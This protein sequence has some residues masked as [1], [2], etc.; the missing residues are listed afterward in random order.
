MLFVLVAQAQDTLTLR[1]VPTDTS[2]EAFSS[3]VKLKTSF[4]RVDRLNNALNQAIADLRNQGFLEASVDSL[5]RS[6]NEF[7]ACMHVGQQYQ[8]LRLRPGNVEPAL[9][10][11]VGF[12]ERVFEGRPVRIESVRALQERLLRFAENHGYP[13]AIAGLDSVEIQGSNVSAALSFSRNELI[14]FDTVVI[15]GGAQ[16]HPK[17]LY[18]YL[19]LKPGAPYSEAIVAAMNR[20]LRELPF[21]QQTKLPEVTF[22]RDGARVDL[23]LDTR[24]V[25]RVNGIIGVLPNSDANDGKLLITADVDLDL[26]NALGLG[27]QIRLRWKNLQP[28]SPQLNVNALYPYVLWWPVGVDGM[29]DLYKKDTSYIDL[30]QELGVRYSFIGYNHIR[31]FARWE[32]SS[33]IWVDTTLILATKKLPAALD[34]QAVISGLELHLEHLD[35]RFNPRK[36]WTLTVSGEAGNRNVRRNNRITSLEDPSDPTFSYSG[37]YDSLE[38]RSLRIGLGTVAGVFLPM[39]KRMTVHAAIAGGARLP[40]RSAFENELLR[41]GG[42]NLLRGFDDEAFLSSGFVVAT[43]EWRYLLA[44]NSFFRFFADVANVSSWQDEQYVQQ[45]PLGIGTGLALETKAGVFGVS[46]AV[47]RL[48]ETSEGFRFRNTK[49]HLGYL[50]FF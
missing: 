38:Q 47:G 3:Y 41:L 31:A 18:N 15:N 16:I 33:L 44:V 5:S 48:L 1:V 6:G 19:G 28:L 30:K 22:I 49:V 9:L 7:T 46:A 32:S 40:E 35:Y 2:F 37:L 11:E 45:W 20:R 17:Y 10:N 43:L 8:W 27:E 14:R 36:G 42:N 13:F 23:F 21:V 4:N 12:K 26:R 34:W 29:F 39:A 50:N 25:S 24:K